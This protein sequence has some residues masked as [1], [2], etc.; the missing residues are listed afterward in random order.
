MEG[1]RVV[2]SGRKGLAD[3]CWNSGSHLGMKDQD[4]VSMSRTE[5]RIYVWKVVEKEIDVELAVVVLGGPEESKE[6]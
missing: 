4:V 6:M 2:V 3:N 1:P 5:L